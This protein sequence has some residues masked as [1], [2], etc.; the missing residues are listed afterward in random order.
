MDIKER[1]SKWFSGPRDYSEGLEL[2]KEVSKK[3][4]VLGKLSKGESKTRREKMEYELKHFMGSKVAI[5]APA[6]SKAPGVKTTLVVTSA[7]IKDTGKEKRFS[8][9]PK[10]KSLIDYPDSI[11][12]VI[13]ENSSLYMQ[14]GRLHS[15]LT[16]LG[17]DNSDEVKIKRADLAGKIEKTSA[18]LDLLYSVF[19]KYETEGIDESDTL[20]PEENGKP[21]VQLSIDELK[22]EKKNLQASLTKD[23]NQLEYQ[24][25]TKPEN[26]VSNPMPAGPKRIKLEKRIKAKEA[27]VLAID[28]EIAERS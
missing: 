6:P 15:Q 1:I 28:M 25:K 18:R 21:K 7:A 12:R 9:I 2:L 5:P 27:Q 11:K 8:L 22:Q 24:G 13:N 20:Y 16:K 19:L 23:R 26:G 3:S 4:H 17:D 10:G 14:R